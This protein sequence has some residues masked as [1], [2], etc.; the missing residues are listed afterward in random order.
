MTQRF[1]TVIIGAGHNGLVCAYE[2]ARRGRSVLVVEAAARVGGAAVTREFAPGYRVSAGAHLVQCLPAQIVQGMALERHGLQFCARDLP[3]TALG[4]DGAAVVFAGGAVTGVGAADVRS[5]AR[6]VL[7]MRR[8]ARLMAQ[9]LDAVP[10]RLSFATWRERV[11]ALVLALRIRLLGRRDMR[12]FLR[13]IGMNAYDL[14]EDSFESPLLKA[15]LGVDATLGAEHG[16]RSPGTVLTYLYRLAGL[17]RGAGL[18]LAQ[19]AG[20]MGAVS[21]AM[22]AAAQGAGAQVRTGARVRRVL[23]HNDRAC[24][25]ELESGEV[26][27]AD[28]VVSNADPRTTFLRL[29][30]PEHLDTDFI[31]RI[32]HFRARGKVA[33]VHLALDGAPRWR[34]AGAEASRGRIVVAPSLRYVD[35][36]AFNPSKYNR[37]TDH[38][39][40]E[41]TVPTA[42]DPALAPAGH[43]VLSINV[44]FVP[45][46]PA[47]D[48]AAA[49]IQVLESVLA[50]LE[51]VAPGLRAQVVATELLTPRD[52]ER[53]FGMSGGHWHHGALEFDQF[54]F[55]RPV[56]GAADYS[57][58]VPGL[59]LCGSGAH[60]GG[61]V[62]GMAGRNAAAR[63]LRGGC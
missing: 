4:A 26:I 62:T 60:P 18:G 16:P 46:A 59:Y 21:A 57:T 8:F 29:V 33:K 63:I 9:V 54:F 1:N 32:D 7:R 49:R 3:T 2:L 37:V 47:G 30:G 10:F 14:F 53:E 38:P 51:K 43:H 56:P 28:T 41:V 20:G 50:A 25:V 12:E 58:P 19:P 24:G 13:I 61:G 48:A 6:F 5:Y 23:V 36:D 15:A 27:A 34:G 55:T 42:N 52:L 31:R 11:Q 44:M 45:Y 40:L 22:A 39:V 17:E 35:E